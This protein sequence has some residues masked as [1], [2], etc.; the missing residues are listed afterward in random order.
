MFWARH[1]F[2]IGLIALGVVLRELPVDN[3]LLEL[4]DGLARRVDSFHTP[5]Q[6]PAPA[7]VQVLDRIAE[8]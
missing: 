8:L 5:W 3:V 2:S 6:T 4:E 1:Q 7:Q